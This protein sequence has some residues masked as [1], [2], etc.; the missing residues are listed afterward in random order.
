MDWFRNLRRLRVLVI[1]FYALAI[2]S[3]GFVH[4]TVSAAAPSQDLSAF[5]LPD[6]SLPDICAGEAQS[7]DQHGIP[8]SASKGLC[9]ACLLTSAPGSV[10]SVECWTPVKQAVLRL[11]FQDASPQLVVRATAHVPHLRGPPTAA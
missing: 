4:H 7:S 2:A 5:V 9:D 3:L 10:L 8:Q 11:L 6:G 1:A